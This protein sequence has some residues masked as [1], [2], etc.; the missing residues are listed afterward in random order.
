MNRPA[1][2]MPA[3]AKPEGSGTTLAVVSRKLQAF[4]TPTSNRAR[5]VTRRIHVPWASSPLKTESGLMPTDEWS[6]L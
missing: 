6:M 1:N 4:S 2:P 5:S 3:R